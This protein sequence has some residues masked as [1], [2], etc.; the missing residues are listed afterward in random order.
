MEV[1][2]LCKSSRLARMLDPD[3]N[4]QQ[5]SCEG[6]TNGYRPDQPNVVL[7]SRDLPLHLAPKFCTRRKMATSVTQTSLHPCNL[8]NFRGAAHAA[9]QMVLDDC[10]LVRRKLI[11]QIGAEHGAGR[12]T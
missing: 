4:G 2:K 10:R 5:D 3:E 8:R 1:R 12:T 6:D 11:I 7:R 9:S